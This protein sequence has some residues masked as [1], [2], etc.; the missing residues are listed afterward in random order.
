MRKSLKI[1]TIATVLVLCMAVLFGCAGTDYR[2]VL[3]ESKAFLNTTET[4][5][6]QT[7]IAGYVEKHM[8]TNDG[9]VKKAIILGFDGTRADA[10]LNIVGEK[11]AKGEIINFDSMYSGVNYLRNQTD[12]GLYLAFCGGIENDK[13]T[14][15]AASTSPGFATILT[16]KWGVENGVIDNGYSLKTDQKTILR[17]YAENG[18]KVS[19]TACWPDHFEVVFTNE[20]EAMANN[21]NYRITRNTDDDQTQANILSAINTEDLIFS[22]YEWPDH[23][24]HESNFSND[25]YRYVKSVVDSDRRAYEVITAVY[26]RMEKNPNEDWLIIMSTDH[27][28]LKRSHGGQSDEER[29]IWI[30]SNKNLIGGN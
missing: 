13:V 28:G 14:K 9:K 30:A 19:F 22:I 29:F 15:Q 8:N 17:K 16:G 2:Q 6:S 27:G 24:G 10:M 26:E 7:E 5:I 23:N 3:D 1:A 11:N 21:E 25:N 18:K 12:G 4:A 20:F